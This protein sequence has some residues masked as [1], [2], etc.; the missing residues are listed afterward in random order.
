VPDVVDTPAE[1]AGGAFES[2]VRKKAAELKAELIRQTLEDIESWSKAVELEA[3]RAH[4]ESPHSPLPPAEVEG[5][6]NKVRNGYYDW[7]EPAFERYLSPDPDAI[8]PMIDGLRTIESTFG[9][10]QDGAGNFTPASPA[11]GRVNDVRTDMSQWQ[12]DFQTDFIDNFL[13]PLQNVSLNQAAVAKVVREQL[14]VNKAL[15]ISYRKSVLDL[16]DKS[17]DAVKTL[18]NQRDPKSFMWGTVIVVAIGTALTLGTG[19][20]LVAGTLLS[21]SG[22]LAQGA[23]PDAKKKLDLGAPTAQEVAVKISEAMVALDGDT[24]EEERKVADALTALSNAIA[25]SRQASVANNKS[26]D[27]AVAM[28]KVAT[29]RPAEVTDG[30]LRPRD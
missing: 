5:Y 8:N 6:R 28:P 29:A 16:L 14:E 15:Y 24:Y 3:A 18:N 2:T 1:L 30:S 17:I 23:V 20:V 11:L 4:P 21:I 19:A 7:V 10:S 25:D 27:L 26:G 13:T 12:G 22:T 9:G